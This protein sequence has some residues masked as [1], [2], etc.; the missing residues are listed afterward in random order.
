MELVFENVKQTPRQKGGAH[1]GAGAN[2]GGNAGALK[3][4]RTNMPSYT[5]GELADI[6]T[7]HMH[8][9]GAGFFGDMWDGIKSG[10]NT[11]ASI[12]QPILSIIP[13]PGAQM[14]SQALGVTQ[15]LLGH[16]KRARRTGGDGLTGAGPS[17]LTGAGPSGLTGAGKKKKSRIE[18]VNT[19][20]KK[21]GLSMIE[22][23]KYVKANDLW[24]S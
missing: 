16:G 19:V 10:F 1:T 7:H 22:A 3:G 8:V 2:T 21:Q 23:S 11:V 15:G 18:I 12:A 20:M 5:A 4:R 9:H 6:V 14:A 17:G 24:K 13:H